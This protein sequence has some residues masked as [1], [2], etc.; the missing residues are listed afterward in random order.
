MHWDF[1]AEEVVKGQ[2]AYG[3]VEFRR[4][5]YREVLANT[6]GLVDGE[7]ALACFDVIYDYTY[8][9]AT[10]RRPEAFALMPEAPVDMAFLEGIRETIA[11]NVTMLGAILQRL[12]MD[13]VENGLGVDAAVSAAARRHANAAAQPLAAACG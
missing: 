7:G 1:T 12:I 10:G 2:V 3:I 8:W 4:D 6:K 11:P 5:L 9:L 13:G